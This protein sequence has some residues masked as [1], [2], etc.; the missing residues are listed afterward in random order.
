MGKRLFLRQV[1][2]LP[3]LLRQ[4]PRQLHRQEQRQAKAGAGEAEV[5]WAEARAAAVQA[6]WVVV[7]QVEAQRALDEVEVRRAPH[8]CRDS[9]TLR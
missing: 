7:V 6:A 8:R 1:W 2:R 3:E 4:R 5:V 9:K